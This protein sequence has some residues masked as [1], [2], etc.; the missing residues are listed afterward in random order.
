MKHI[1]PLGEPIIPMWVQIE[2]HSGI[3][4]VHEQVTVWEVL[5]GAGNTGITAEEA[6]RLLFGIGEKKKP[7]KSQV[8]NTRNKINRL[9]R[10]GKAE[11]FDGLNSFKRYRL[12]VDPLGVA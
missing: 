2:R 7:N 10:E 5:K 4:T 9:I 12:T 3:V 6:A 8:Q 1:K 11:E